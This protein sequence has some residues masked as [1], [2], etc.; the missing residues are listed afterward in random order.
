M[1]DSGPD[2]RDFDNVFLSKYRL[3]FALFFS[4]EIDN[5]PVT[6]PWQ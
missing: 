4:A 6:V 5:R 1:A 2:R 3:N